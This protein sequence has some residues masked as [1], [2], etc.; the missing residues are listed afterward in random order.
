MPYSPASTEEGPEPSL[1]LTRAGFPICPPADS[2]NIFQDK[3]V[4]NRV[5]RGTMP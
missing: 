4:L 5:G 3:G 1:P 2:G